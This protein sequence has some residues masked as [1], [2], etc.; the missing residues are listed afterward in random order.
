M[1]ELLTLSQIFCYPKRHLFVG[2]IPLLNIFFRLIVIQLNWR[3][4]RRHEHTS[5]G[6]HWERRSRAKRL[7]D[8]R[9]KWPFLCKSYSEIYYL[10]YDLF[11][12]NSAAFRLRPFAVTKTKTKADKL[13]TFFARWMFLIIINHVCFYILIYDLWYQNPE[14]CG[15]FRVM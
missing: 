9:I 7:R 5:T 14:K 3:K 15:Q 2:H 6:D 11:E 8:R 1:S 10:K 12:I 4:C 13:F